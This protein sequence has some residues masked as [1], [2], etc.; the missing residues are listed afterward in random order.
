M[1]LEHEICI[2]AT[3]LSSTEI[4]QELDAR[5]C[6]SA[7]MAHLV[8]FLSEADEVKF[9]GQW[10]PIK[11]LTESSVAGVREIVEQL[12]QWSVGDSKGA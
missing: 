8:Q 5:S 7:T 4:R 10:R 3:A 12:H 1:Y 11:S 6:P 9:S 2:P